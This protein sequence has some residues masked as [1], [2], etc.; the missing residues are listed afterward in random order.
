MDRK[1]DQSG[2]PD[3]PILVNDEDDNQSEASDYESTLNLLK[4]F[5]HLTKS[6]SDISFDTQASI[7]DYEHGKDF[8]RFSVKQF[9]L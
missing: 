6:I 9:R 8:Q 2:A 3:D 4:Q 1:F 7:F 5:D